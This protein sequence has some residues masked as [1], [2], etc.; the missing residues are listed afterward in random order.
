MQCIWTLH[1]LPHLSS[2]SPFHINP[3]FTSV[4]SFLSFPSPPP[5]PFLSTSLFT[6][7]PFLPPPPPPPPPIS[8]PSSLMHSCLPAR[9]P[10]PTGAS[11]QVSTAKAVAGPSTETGR[12]RNETNMRG[13][14]AGEWDSGS[15]GRKGNMWG[16]GV[17]RREERAGKLKILF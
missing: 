2:P 9:Q 4:S 14:T 5:P 10:H 17:G 6:F 16:D 3:S 15:R 13:K 1:F 12:G 11:G 7:C 8:H